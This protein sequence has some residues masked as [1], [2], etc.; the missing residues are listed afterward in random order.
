MPVSVITIK[1]AIDDDIIASRV[2][3]T[4]ESHTIHNLRAVGI[5]VA[6]VEARKPVKKVVVMLQD[7]VNRQLHHCG[8]CSIHNLQ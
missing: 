1:S 6:E 3:K 2:V 8:N 4:I 5:N 7:D